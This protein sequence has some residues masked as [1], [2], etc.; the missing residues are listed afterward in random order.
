M[1]EVGDERKNN[2]SGRVRRRAS[3]LPKLVS[4]SF[5]TLRDFPQPGWSTTRGFELADVLSLSIENGRARG[6]EDHHAGYDGGAHFPYHAIEVVC[7]CGRHR[8]HL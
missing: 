5:V 7:S 6:P 2:Q 4:A 1:G 3:A 8:H